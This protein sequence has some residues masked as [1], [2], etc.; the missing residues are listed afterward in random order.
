MII[1]LLSTCTWREEL[2]NAKKPTQPTAHVESE[3][4]PRVSK[5]IVQH[6]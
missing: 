6:L 4:G 2:R 1:E 5:I 3:Q